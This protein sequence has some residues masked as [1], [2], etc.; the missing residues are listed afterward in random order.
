MI[1]RLAASLAALALALAGAVLVSAPAHAQTREVDSGTLAWGF[2]QSFRSYV[3]RQIAAM[4]PLGAAP[5]GERITVSAGARFDLDGTPAFPGST[6]DPNETLP[7]LFDTSGGSVSDADNLVVRTAGAVTYHFPSHHFE[8]TIS[9]LTVVVEQGTARLVGDIY[10]LAT[11]DFGDFVAGEYTVGQGTIGTVANVD[12]MIDGDE[13]TV[14]GT[15]L[16]VHE[17]GASALPQNVGEELDD[18]TLTATLGEVVEDEPT[19]IT[20]PTPA[21]SPEPGELV[22]SVDGSVRSVSFGTADVT[23][24]GFLATA[25]LPGVVVTDARAGGPA[26][27]VTAE[28]SDFTSDAGTIRAR[29]LGWLPTLLSTGGGAVVGDMVPPRLASTDGK[30]KGLAVARTLGFAPAGHAKGSATLGGTLELL[31]PLGT[32]AGSYRAVLT[33]TAVS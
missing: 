8:I 11:Q 33:I 3:G 10:Q 2:K 1:R 16:A 13:V 17:D 21:P 32:K 28:V 4:P 18:F 20:P 6:S 12:V 7:Y 19:P 29:H 25:T 9:N 27:R 5:E 24:G 22:W 31:A 15:G 26:W 14:H 30:G 23:D